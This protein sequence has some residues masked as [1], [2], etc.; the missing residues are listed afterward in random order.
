MRVIS[1]LPHLSPGGD[2]AHIAYI[3]SLSDQLSFSFQSKAM[4]GHNIQ[5]CLKDSV[6]Y[7]SAKSLSSS[8]CWIQPNIII[9]HF[10]QYKF[11][12]ECGDGQKLLVVP[13]KYSGVMYSAAVL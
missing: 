2:Q 9:V 13:S 7:S 12:S 5:I 6:V 8:L 1:P 4:S 3:E 11:Y 10:T